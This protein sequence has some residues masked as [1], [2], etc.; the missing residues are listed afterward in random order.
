MGGWDRVVSNDSNVSSAYS[1]GSL[2]IVG[3]V[4]GRSAGDVR[5]T[6]PVG[7]SSGTD[8][9]DSRSSETDDEGGGNLALVG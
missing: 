2:L 4:C 7:I 5:V 1:V 8:S 3:M 6:S 9:D